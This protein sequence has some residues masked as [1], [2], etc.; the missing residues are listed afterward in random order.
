MDHLPERSAK[1]TTSALPRRPA[2]VEVIQETGDDLRARKH[3]AEQRDQHRH[4]DHVRG[5]GVGQY[6][7]HVEDALALKVQDLVGEGDRLAHQLQAQHL[8]TRVHLDH[9]CPDAHRE[10]HQGRG[11]E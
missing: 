7:D 2:D 10:Q 8:D 6:R 9:R 5:A 1:K 4:Q 3:Q 11:G